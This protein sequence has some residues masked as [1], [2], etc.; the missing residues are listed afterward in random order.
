[1]R[2]TRKPTKAGL[3]NALFVQAAVEDL[4]MELDGVAREIHIHFP[5]GSLLRGVANGEE[6][7]VTSLRRICADG[8]RLTLVLGVD[9][10]RDRSELAR[11]RIPPFSDDHLHQLSIA[12]Q[13]GGFTVAALKTGGDLLP[14]FR[15]SWARR[16]G[17]RRSRKMIY[18]VLKAR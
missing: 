15:T 1:M 11:L 3:P 9:E 4:P 7:F 2:A 16:L 13:A 10:I 12:Y 5:W 6:W 14:E 17:A 8:A 18:I